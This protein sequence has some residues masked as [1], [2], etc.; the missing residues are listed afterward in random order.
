LAPHQHA[1]HSSIA[2]TTQPKR[3]QQCHL[4]RYN[5]TVMCDQAGC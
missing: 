3:H 1:G 5:T 2:A 4:H